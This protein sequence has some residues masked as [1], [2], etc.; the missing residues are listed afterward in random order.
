MNNAVSQRYTALFSQHYNDYA[1]LFDRVKLNLNP[2]IKGRN[3]PTP[4]AV[5]KLPGRTAGL[6]FGRIIFSIRPLSVDFKFPSGQYAGEF[7]GYLA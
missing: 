7:A 3:L 2:A 1:A 6:L 4:P 5:E